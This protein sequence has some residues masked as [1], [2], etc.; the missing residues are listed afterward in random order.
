MAFTGQTPWHG[1]GQRLTGNATL[2][3]WTRE[4]GMDWQALALTPEFTMPDGERRTY[5]DKRIIVRDDTRA[6]LSVM[7][8]G[9]KIV[10]PREVMG[11]FQSL[12]K[13]GE[14]QLHTAG[15][16]DGGRRMWALAK[17]GHGGE[18]VKG[19]RVRQFL[20]LATS[21]DGTTK[22]VAAFTQVRV[23]CANTIAIALQGAHKDIAKHKARGGAAQA[24]AVSHKSEFDAD[25]VKHTL[26]LAG[27][28]WAQFQIMAQEL[29]GRRCGMEEAR[30]I[31]RQ[32]FGQPVGKRGAKQATE[33][34]ADTAAAPQGDTLAA[35]LA[36]APAH[37]VR[38][39]ITAEARSDLAR[40]LSGSKDEREQRSVAR[41]LELFAGAGRGAQADGVAGTRWGLLNAV[42]EHI[43]HEQG[44]TA[45][46]SLTSAWFGRGAQFKTNAVNLLT[47]D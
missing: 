29:A 8:E 45:D 41:C 20:M 21:L 4:A 40:M 12:I 13:G 39:D 31:L 11:F 9:Y 15:V 24:V 19:D 7:G 30:S 6:P 14:F 36:A 10:Q 35:L 33:K 27:E 1:L 23:V 25:D 17:N 42:T 46:S 44:R 38:D 34:A 5:E 2:E 43:D 3:Q 22:T 18:I 47:G 32:L 26:G 37:V 16:L 28:T